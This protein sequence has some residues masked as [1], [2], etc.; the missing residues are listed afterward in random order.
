MDYRPYQPGRPL[1][2]AERVR[3][4]TRKRFVWLMVLIGVCVG[5]PA[6]YY[7]KRFF[8]WTPKPPL[9][10]IRLPD[11]KEVRLIATFEGPEYT[12]HGGE[13]FDGKLTGER[14]QNGN[15]STKNCRH[16]KGPTA[17]LILSVWDPGSKSFDEA[18]ELKNL[19]IVD[20]ASLTFS[21]KHFVTPDDMPPVTLFAFE[22]VPRRPPTLRVRFV[23]HGA[24]IEASLPN[25][26]ARPTAP[27]FAGKPLPQSQTV[28]GVQ[29]DLQ[30]LYV[31]EGQ[32]LE[33]R[34]KAYPSGNPNQTLQTSFTCFDPTGNEGL[35]RRLP[36]ADRVLG[37]HVVAKPSAGTALPDTSELK[38]GGFRIPGRNEAVL[39][40]VPDALAQKEI[41]DIVVLGTGDF[42]WINL[43]LNAVLSSNGQEERKELGTIRNRQRFRHSFDG[44]TLVL[45]L[46]HTGH[47]PIDPVKE[48]FVQLQTSGR[49]LVFSNAG[50]LVDPNGA[51]IVYKPDSPKE[52]VAGAEVEFVVVYP[53]ARTAEFFFERPKL[54]GE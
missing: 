3:Q 29:F 53:K 18:N 13:T 15:D 33:I 43:K 51:S 42:E 20:G 16:G 37:L 45:M 26:F 41:T 17:W 14:V 22:M 10:V 32:S 28:N 9:A 19:E 5:P 38:L 4:W 6:V 54:P 44:P 24:T 30:R 39:L 35:F 23:Y 21:P 52:L 11:G 46:P 25:H 48:G 49:S 8:P 2:D 12:L 31:T 36:L 50:H 7:A 27:A 34:V 1:A 40:K 47:Y